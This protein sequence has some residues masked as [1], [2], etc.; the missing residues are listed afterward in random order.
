MLWGKTSDLGNIFVIVTGIQM[1]LMAALRI[2]GGMDPKALARSKN[3]TWRS[4]SSFFAAWI[5]CHIMVEC[6]KHPEIPVILAYQI[7]F[8]LGCHLLQQR[9]TKYSLQHPEDLFAGFWG[10]LIL[11][12][13]GISILNALD[14]FGKFFF[15]HTIF[16]TLHGSLRTSGAFYIGGWIW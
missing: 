2:V 4:L 11:L 5:W 3:A 9:W 13:L 12:S 14:D 6:S 8:L 15:L 7:V 10:I 1:Y 16:I